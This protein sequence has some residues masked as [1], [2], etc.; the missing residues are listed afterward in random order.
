[1]FG[2]SIHLSVHLCI[3]FHEIDF[4]KNRQNDMRE[5]K[6]ECSQVIAFFGDRNFRAVNMKIVTALRIDGLMRVVTMEDM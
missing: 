1:M 3:A 2:K 5:R 6:C 4:N